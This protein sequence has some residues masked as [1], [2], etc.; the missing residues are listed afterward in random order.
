MTKQAF[1]TRSQRACRL[2]I[3]VSHPLDLLW[4]DLQWGLMTQVVQEGTFHVE[5]QKRNSNSKN[6]GVEK[7][8][9]AEI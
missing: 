3:F 2:N 6:S 8:K 5:H 1:H 9:M 4:V 7:E